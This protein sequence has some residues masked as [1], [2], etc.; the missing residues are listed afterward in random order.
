M[1]DDQCP[2]PL[3]NHPPRLQLKKRNPEADITDPRDLEPQEIN[4]LD[5]A[6]ENQVKYNPFRF[7]YK[8]IL[9]EL[10][11]EL[12]IKFIVDDL[13]HNHKNTICFTADDKE[14]EIPF[15]PLQAEPGS[16][17]PAD[18]WEGP[19]DYYKSYRHGER[20]CF[21]IPTIVRA[22]LL[23]DGMEKPDVLVTQEFVRD[24]VTPAR[25][26]QAIADFRQQILGDPTAPSGLKVL[27]TDVLKEV[28][29]GSSYDDDYEEHEDE[30][31]WG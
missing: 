7:C 8:V 12:V 4:K 3:F 28:D 27:L 9:E 2:Q 22:K 23:G 15:F 31:D 19:D 6:I 25:L 14:Y 29:G 11:L 24:Y 10:N 5:Q 20:T 21:I 1:Y 16:I 17:D 18:T 30:D 26:Q 13:D